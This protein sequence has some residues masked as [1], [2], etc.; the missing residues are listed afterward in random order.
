MQ[1][2][3]PAC[4]LQA[5]A[6]SSNLEAPQRVRKL[7]ASLARL[8]SLRS[9]S[10]EVEALKVRLLNA[11]LCWNIAS[12]VVG[13]TNIHN[14]INRGFHQVHMMRLKHFMTCLAA[15]WQ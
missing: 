4:A 5:E 2:Q 13:D 1:A 15:R 3:E 10:A 8:A 12:G 9:S 6:L 14:R 11:T 7:A